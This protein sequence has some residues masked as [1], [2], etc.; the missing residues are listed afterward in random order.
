MW[1]SVALDAAGCSKH[2]AR[3][4][5]PTQVGCYATHVNIREAFNT[6]SGAGVKLSRFVSREINF[7]NIDANLQV[8]F[9]TGISHAAQML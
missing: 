9:G 6:A 5:K 4:P 1:I 7:V 2:P 8:F 3:K